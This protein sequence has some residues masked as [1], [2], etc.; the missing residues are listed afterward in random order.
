MKI[1]FIRIQSILPVI[2]SGNQK[3]IKILSLNHFKQK[4]LKSK[5][6]FFLYE[7]REFN[8]NSSSNSLLDGFLSFLIK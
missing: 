7:L 6:N 8:Q 5:T 3:L 4:P 2:V 1:F